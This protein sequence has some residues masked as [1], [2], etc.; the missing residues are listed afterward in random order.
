VEVLSKLSTLCPMVFNHAFIEIWLDSLE[1][2]NKQDYSL[3]SDQRKLIKQ[4]RTNQS[5]LHDQRKLIKQIRTNQ[6]TPY[7]LLKTS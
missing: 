7:N 2:F 5:I 6:S 1:V 3:W 4:I